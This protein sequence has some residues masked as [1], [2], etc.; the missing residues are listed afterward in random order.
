MKLKCP[1]LFKCP[2]PSENGNV[3]DLQA[4]YMLPNRDQYGRRIYIIRMG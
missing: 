2:Y 3:F 1:E 4:Q